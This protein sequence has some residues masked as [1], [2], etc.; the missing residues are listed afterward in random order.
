MRKKYF[1]CHTF[2]LI[3]VLIS[4]MMCSKGV[5]PATVV[6]WDQILAFL[7]NGCCISTTSTSAAE[8]VTEAIIVLLEEINLT[9]ISKK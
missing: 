8:P 9:S 4:W 6:V 7:F 1:R 3:I 5:F 2:E